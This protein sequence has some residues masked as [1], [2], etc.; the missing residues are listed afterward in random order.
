[1][2]PAAAGFQ[3]LNPSA[4]LSIPPWFHPR[5]KTKT[6]KNMELNPKPIPQS[7][8]I[9]T[10]ALPSGSPE[11]ASSAKT[12]PAIP[13]TKLLK[14]EATPYRHNTADSAPPADKICYESEDR[15]FVVHQLVRKTAKYPPSNYP[16]VVLQC[17]PSPNTR[18]R[19]IEGD[20]IEIMPTFKELE[21]F[22]VAINEAAVNSGKGRLYEILQRVPEKTAA[23]KRKWRR[24]NETRLGI[25]KHRR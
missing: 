1:M 25:H 23:H 13:V 24:F 17:R 16:C 20:Y 4:G 6:T 10:A 19:K 11:L 7:P 5:S 12:A 22:V 9:T 8:P 15:Q 21:E 18:V 3:A 2:D 14:S